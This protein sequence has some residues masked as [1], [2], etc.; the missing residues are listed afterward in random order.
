MRLEADPAGDQVDRYDRLLRY[1][2]LDGKNFNA[3]LIREGYATAIR[4]FPYSRKSEFLRPSR[5]RRGRSAVGYGPTR[6]GSPTT[7][8]HEQ[9]DDE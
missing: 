2:Y 6:K 4:T 7:T 5:P 3:R 8:N 9:E 1:V